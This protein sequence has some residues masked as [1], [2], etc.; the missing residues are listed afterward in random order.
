MA[1]RSG[2]EELAAWL[3]K[4]IAGRV[5]GHAASE[6][7]AKPLLSALN[8]SRM[9]EQ[10]F[11]RELL[12][13]LDGIRDQLR[14]VHTSLVMID[15]A[16]AALQATIHRYAI[17]AALDGYYE[18]AD[19][20]HSRFEFF[21]NG[22][23]AL[24]DPNADHDRAAAD[25]FVRLS[26]PNDAVLSDAMNRIHAFV[27]P[28]SGVEGLFDHL[29]TGM[30]D[31]MN[32][33]AADESNYRIEN[34]SQPLERFYIPTDRGVFST[35]TMLTGSFSAATAYLVN[36]AVPLM[37][38]VLATEIKGLVLLSRAWAGGPHDRMIRRYVDNILRH[39]SLMQRF[40]DKRAVPAVKK[41]AKEILTKPH[42]RLTGDTLRRA[43]WSQLPLD[44]T[45]PSRTL[46]PIRQFLLNDEWV[47][48]AQ[49]P[50]ISDRWLAEQT[51]LPPAE[52]R[53]AEWANRRPY[54]VVML[55]RPWLGGVRRAYL[56]S[57]RFGTIRDHMM[58]LPD[59][60]QVEARDAH[61]RLEFTDG[62]LTRL[63]NQ[64]WQFH[65]RLGTH[66]A[67]ILSPSDF[68]NRTDVTTFL[69]DHIGE[70]AIGGDSQLGVKVD[71]FSDTPPAALTELLHELPVK[72]AELAA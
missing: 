71:V 65:P 53:V 51:A 13:Q 44:Q 16:V 1:E 20:I 14:E 50:E 52:G 47:M 6:L 29:L 57:W 58:R 36:V 41:Q 11:Q 59:F 56:F 69:S 2:D 42:L 10:A 37:T 45:G 43:R 21:I 5:I 4:T 26:A 12:A 27:V 22:V 49:F 60:L 15:T 68:M 40:F 32:A 25:L 3:A 31:A 54:P 35:R 38:H 46:Q 9:S 33:F 30:R 72:R 48:W 62:V 61:D 39:V 63:I 67:T 7:I 34:R 28:N 66:H 70:I 8:V 55:H 19:M 23:A 17:S 18:R 64:S 24:T